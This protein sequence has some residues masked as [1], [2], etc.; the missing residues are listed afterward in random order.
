MSEKFDKVSLEREIAKEAKKEL[1]KSKTVMIRVLITAAIVLVLVGTYIILTNRDNDVTIGSGDNEI[2][3]NTSA[4]LAEISNPYNPAVL[5]IMEDESQIVIEL[6][7]DY[8]PLT[9]SN[10]VQL[11]E[12]GFYDNLT[13]HRIMHNFMMQG[14]DPVGNGTGG[15]DQL[16]VG[17]FS[18]NGI[19]NPLRHTR[20][21]VSMARLGNDFNSA[22][23]QFFIVQADSSFL[24]NAYAVFGFI[25]Y[26]MEDVDYMIN[27]SNPLDSNGTILHAE[28]PVIRTAAVI[29]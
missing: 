27:S 18:Q 6:F 25:I 14:G 16:I 9:V 24:D 2:N 7:P 22:S 17:E 15:S 19:D 11:V 5:L 23:S 3:V 28:Q 12:D 26:G 4:L 29:N 21:A 20:G 1:D 13:F 10:F 8:A